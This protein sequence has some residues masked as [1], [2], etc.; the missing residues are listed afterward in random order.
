MTRLAPC[1]A[2]A[3]AAGAFVFACKSTDPTKSR[4]LDATVLPGTTAVPPREDVSYRALGVSPDCNEK[5]FSYSELLEIARRPEIK[6]QQEFLDALPKGIMQ[7]FTL[8]HVSESAQAEGV[9]EDFPGAIRMTQDGR[10]VFRYTCDPRSPVYGGIEVMRFDEPTQSFHFT[11]IHFPNEIPERVRE[12]AEDCDGCHDHGGGGL[13][14]HWAMYPDWPG[15]FGSHDDFFPTGT[16]KDVEQVS[17]AA[18]WAP[19]AVAKEHEIFR[20]FLDAKVLKNDAK[21]VSPDPCYAALPWP[22]PFLEGGTVPPLYAEY[23]FGT[24]NAHAGGRIYALRP[25]LKLTEIFSKLLARRNTRHILAHAEYPKVKLLLAFEAARCMA[26]PL[27][28]NRK[29]SYAQLHGLMKKALPAYVAP[30]ASQATAVDLRGNKMLH[31]DP[32]HPK[33]LAQ[34]LFGAAKVMGLEGSDWTLVYS[35]DSPAFETGAGPGANAD[36]PGDLPLTAYVQHEI[37]ADVATDPRV[38]DAALASLWTRGTGETDDF[39]EHF[40]C[41]DQLAG[42]TVF[43]SE[44]ARVGVCDALAKLIQ[45]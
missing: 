9:S 23:P 37:L 6:T 15:F 34:S 30:L 29:I 4:T 14:P 13:R 12:D 31:H 38:A 1:L 8:M 24:Y 21:G 36:F 19:T 44:A 40:A 5:A 45:P 7:T 16:P 3:A 22:K 11:E 42:P 27:A 2:F 10:L 26:R 17:H 39:G 33:S 35:G 20:R 41:I 25:N 32:R 43:K 28:G 18:G